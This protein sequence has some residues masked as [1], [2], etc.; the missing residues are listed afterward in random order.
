MHEMTDEEV[1]VKTAGI[2]KQTGAVFLVFLLLVAAAVGIVI[3][4]AHTLLR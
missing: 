1:A 3:L 2:K 4:K